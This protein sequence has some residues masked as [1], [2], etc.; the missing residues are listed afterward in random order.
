MEDSAMGT[1]RDLLI[2]HCVPSGVV[3]CVSSKWLSVMYLK[4]YHS[5]MLFEFSNVYCPF[6]QV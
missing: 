3:I 5:K 1:S 6:E 4:C 2:L